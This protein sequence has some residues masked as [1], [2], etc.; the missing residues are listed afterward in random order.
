MC[1]KSLHNWEV[2]VSERG[3]FLKW[4][5][6][7]SPWR[8][9]NHLHSVSETECSE[10]SEIKFKSNSSSFTQSHSTPSQHPLNKTFSSRESSPFDESSGVLDDVYVEGE[11]EKKSPSKYGGKTYSIRSN[12]Q[13]FKLKKGENVFQVISKGT[14]L[15]KSLN[16]PTVIVKSLT[17]NLDKSMVYIVILEVRADVNQK[18]RH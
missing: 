15:M 12:Q 2:P 10:S 18:S 9:E 8:K 11:N 3:G 1:D 17:G 16:F 14:K 13:E 6:K 5:K 4:I 7:R